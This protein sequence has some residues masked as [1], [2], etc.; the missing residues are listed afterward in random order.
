MFDADSTTANIALFCILLSVSTSTFEQLSVDRRR[1]LSGFPQFAVP[2]HPDVQ[3]RISEF[4]F[5]N[6]QLSF[7]KHLQLHFRTPHHR[8]LTETPQPLAFFGEFTPQTSLAWKNIRPRAKK[9]GVP[10]FH[11]P[12]SPL[13]AVELYGV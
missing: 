9:D 7:G 13:H 11:S 1:I 4:R 12:Q 10:R 6:L 3:S 8:I 2:S 5:G